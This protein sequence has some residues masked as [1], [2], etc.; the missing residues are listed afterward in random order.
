MGSQL[1]NTPQMRVWVDGIS[2]GISHL[3]MNSL[4]EFTLKG[5]HMSDDDLNELRE[6]LTG[7]SEAYQSE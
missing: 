1:V 2:K 6:S 4:W 3:R 7:L 5:E